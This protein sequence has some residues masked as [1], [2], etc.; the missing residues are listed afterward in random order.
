[1]IIRTI[2]ASDIKRQFNTHFGISEGT[3]TSPTYNE[4]VMQFLE[5]MTLLAFPLILL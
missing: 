1:M 5:R 2:K 4:R 3:S